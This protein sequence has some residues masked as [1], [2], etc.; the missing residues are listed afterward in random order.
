MKGLTPKVIRNLF[1]KVEIE[2][3]LSLYNDFPVIV[4][5]KQTLSKKDV[6]QGYNEKL[7]KLFRER[8][9]V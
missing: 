1:G 6:L 9:G 8:L 7:E 4:H 2:E 3:F 5:N